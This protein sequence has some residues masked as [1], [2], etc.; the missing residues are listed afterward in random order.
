MTATSI[1]I[2]FAAICLVIAAILVWV[3]AMATADIRRL[4]FPDG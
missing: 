4:M 2:A 1:V 3:S